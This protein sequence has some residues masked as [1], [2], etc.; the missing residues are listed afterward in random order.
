VSYAKVFE[1]PDVGQY[2]DCGPAGRLRISKVDSTQD[3]WCKI[4]FQ[5]IRADKSLMLMMAKGKRKDLPWSWELDSRIVE[6]DLFG[7]TPVQKEGEAPL[8]NPKL[9]IPHASNA[10][11][12]VCAGCAVENDHQASWCISCGIRLT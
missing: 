4:Q 11:S 12:K 10:V 2:L 9:G 8:A 6:R 3:G 7:W 1:K 5:A